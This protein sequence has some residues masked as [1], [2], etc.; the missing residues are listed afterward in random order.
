[1]MKISDFFWKEDYGAL[2][3]KKFFQIIFCL[4]F[5]FSKLLILCVC[6]TFFIIDFISLLQRFLHYFIF[7][8]TLH[9][10]CSI[11]CYDYHLVFVYLFWIC[12]F[13]FFFRYKGFF[14]S[15]PSG[16][17]NVF[18]TKSTLKRMK[19]IF[20]FTLKLFSFLRYWNVM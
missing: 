20:Y 18:A 17:G 19:T 12:D 7:Y 16:V 14:E 1:M 9:R 6:F 10:K 13:F 3:Q 15:A 4:I 5:N 11:N 8:N 2:R